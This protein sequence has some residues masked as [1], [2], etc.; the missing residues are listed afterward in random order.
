PGPAKYTNRAHFFGT[1]ARAM[2]R[3]LIEHARRRQTK[4]RGG[5]WHRVALEDADLVGVDAPDFIA[6]DEALKRLHGSDPR[7]HQI[8]ELRIFAGLSTGEIASVL[9][10]GKSTIRR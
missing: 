10:R 3:T 1:V 5:A 2:R 8:A 4:K 9:R 6:V 7:L